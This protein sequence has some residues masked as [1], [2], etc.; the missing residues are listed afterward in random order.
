MSEEEY[1]DLSAPAPAGEEAPTPEVNT[2]V[3]PEVKPE[4]EN[5]ETAADTAETPQDEEAKKSLPGSQ[6]QKL[7]AQRLAAELEQTRRELEAMRQQMQPQHQTR[8]DDAE[9]TIDKFD[10]LEEFVS[11]KADYVARKQ[12]ERY[13]YEQ[14]ERQ[15]RDANQRQQAEWAHKMEQAIDGSE[16]AVEAIQEFTYFA[17]EAERKAPAVANAIGSA[18]KE[19]DIGP[20]LVIHLGKHPETIERLVGMSPYRAVAE[21]GRI[22]AEIL[23]KKGNTTPK[24][25]QTSAPKPPSPVK[26]VGSA[27]VKSQWTRE[28]DY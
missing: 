16:E 27:P 7:R 5:A 15:A 24:P 9:P 23:A 17:Q 28:I 22:E 20:E 14:L 19:S 2:E 8:V 3:T 4:G 18:L 21:L 6:K 10:T 25:V 26:A 13:Q 11:A 1:L 12:L